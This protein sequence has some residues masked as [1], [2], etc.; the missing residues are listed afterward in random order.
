MP[1][2]VVVQG[3][4]PS[5][6]PHRAQLERAAR[7]CSL[8]PPRPMS[9]RLKPPA[10]SPGSVSNRAVLVLCSQRR[11][12]ERPGTPAAFDVL[13]RQASHH[14]RAASGTEPPGCHLLQHPAGVLLLTDIS[15]GAS[16]LPSGLPPLSTPAGHTLPWTANLGEPPSFPTPQIS[17]S[18]RPGPPSPLLASPHRRHRLDGRAAAS[19]AWPCAMA[20]RAPLFHV[21]FLAQCKAGPLSWAR[22]KAN[23]RSGPCSAIS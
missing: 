19:L 5:A 16:D 10:L 11:A 22:L 20:R 3:A 7:L 14:G 12:E 9:H 8:Q 2:R 1:R 4:A 13:H 15:S 17:P 6:F 21:G 23:D 18:R